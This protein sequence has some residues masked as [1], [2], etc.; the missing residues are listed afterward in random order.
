MIYKSMINKITISFKDESTKIIISKDNIYEDNAK[1]C[2][3]SENDANRKWSPNQSTGNKNKIKLPSIE[4]FSAHK[5][6]END[7]NVKVVTKK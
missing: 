2:Y 3:Y 5:Q 4:P 1:E 6:D 7:S